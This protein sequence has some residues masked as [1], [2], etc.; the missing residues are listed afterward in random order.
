MPT[1]GDILKEL[2]IL[3]QNTG[4]VPHDPVRRKYLAE[5]F[6]LT[7]RPT[8]LYATKWIQAGAGRIEPATISI[9]EEDIEGLMEVIYGIK[10]KSL[11]LILHSPGGSPEAAEA[12]VSYLRSKFDDIRVIVPHAAMSAATMLGCAAN[13]IVMGKHS[14]LGP[15]DPQFILETP[16]GVQAVPAHDILDQFKLA[17]T[18]CTNPKLLTSW[19]PILNQY[20]PGLLVQCK[21][22]IALSEELVRNWLHTYMF[23]G[24]RKGKHQP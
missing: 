1:W 11:D 4:Q 19:I 8:I 12:I 17:Q 24:K 6:A 13:V 2:N 23:Q 3:Q 7:N 15:V 20:G 18:Q 9:N 14:F 21:N 16:I 5:L 10:G 22:A